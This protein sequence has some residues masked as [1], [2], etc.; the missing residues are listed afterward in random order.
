MMMRTGGPFANLGYQPR[1]GKQ[2]LCGKAIQR[3]LHDRTDVSIDRFDVG[4][5]AELGR[6]IDGVE[7]LRDDLG[8]Q[9]KVERDKGQSERQPQ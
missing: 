6:D 3:V 1:T 9:R 5:F 7:D 4:V 2:A 8:G